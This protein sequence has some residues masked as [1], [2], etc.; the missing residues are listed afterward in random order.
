FSFNVKSGRCEA[1]EG[2]GV[3]KIEM[4][5]LPD[6]Y[7]TCDV[8]KGKRYNRETLEVHYKGKSISDVLAMS[9]S[10]AEEFFSEI[11]RIKRKLFGLTGVGLGYVRLGQPAPTLSGG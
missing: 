11:P 5:F 9:V 3:K 4:N 7:V 6:V 8:C 10:E 1:C 2:D